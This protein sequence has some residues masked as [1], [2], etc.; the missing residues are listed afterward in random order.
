MVSS[1][2]GSAQA[3]LIQVTWLGSTARG[4]KERAATFSS[5]LRS[6]WYTCVSCTSRRLSASALG[7]RRMR[8]AREL[9]IIVAD[10]PL[11]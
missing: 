10:T 6:G 8:S 4:K 5:P 2:K 1:T 3:M 9:R 11:V 7:S